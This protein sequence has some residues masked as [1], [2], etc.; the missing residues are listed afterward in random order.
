MKRCRLLRPRG[1]I[2]HALTSPPQLS[3]KNVQG[4]L[5][6]PL[7]TLNKQQIFRHTHR[8]LNILRKTH[9]CRSHIPH[10]HNQ[11]GIF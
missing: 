8:K 4:N 7:K 2:T 5:C 6:E 1:L 3:P 9:L 11:F 10:N